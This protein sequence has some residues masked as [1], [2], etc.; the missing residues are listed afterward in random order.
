MR[1][2]ER[3]DAPPGATTFDEMRPTL[4][5][6]LGR[7]C[8]YCEYPVKHAPHG[9][10]IIPK[11]KFPAWEHR[12]DNLAVA[13]SWCNGHKG[14]DRP[15]PDRV[16]DYLWPTRDNTARAFTYTNVIPEVAGGLRGDLG[17]KAA[18]LRGLVDLGVTNDDRAKARAETFIQACKFLSRLAGTPDPDL[19]REMILDFAVETGFF[20][21]WMEVFHGDLEIRK[22]LIARFLGTAKSCFDPVTTVPVPRPGGR[23]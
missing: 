5:D 2:V 19:V 9:E 11:D 14:K 20:S 15:A 16:D 6:R 10:H 8:S 18:M 1:P 7:Y 21:V 4:L 3:G 13:C 22:G 23:L 17:N 12:W